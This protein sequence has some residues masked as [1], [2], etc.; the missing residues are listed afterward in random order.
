MCRYI[1]VAIMVFV[2]FGFLM[3]FL[4]TFSYSAVGFNFFYSS[5]VALTAVICMGVATQLV[6]EHE[7][8]EAGYKIQLTMP[9]LI[10]LVI[11][12]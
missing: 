3:T 4:K 9:L 11:Q 5:F 6:G 2:G 8:H 12:W 7:G 10:D 1:H